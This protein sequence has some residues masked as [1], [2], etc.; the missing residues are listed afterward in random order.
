MKLSNVIGILFQMIE[1]TRLALIPTLKDIYK[2]PYL[3]FHPFYVFFTNVWAILGPAMDEHEKEM[4]R[5]L[6]DPHARGVVLDL[7]AGHGHIIKYLDQSKVTK[8]IAL[9][10]NICMHSKIR[11]EAS[12]HGFTESNGNFL[13]IS[14]SASDISSVL[15][16]LSTSIENEEKSRLHSASGIIIEDIRVDTIMTIRSAC[17]FPSPEKTLSRLAKN[18]LKPGGEFLFVEHVLSERKDVAWWQRFWSPI[19]EA[20]AGCRLDRPTHLWIGGIKDLDGEGRTIDM[21]S[22]SEGE[23]KRLAEDPEE[24]LFGHRIGR[25]VKHL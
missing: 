2:N 13:L 8:Y 17:S 4:K 9:E 12:S 14:C 15:F 22:A 7:G 5:G 19:W 1:L 10:P 11:S 20:F 3:I 24:N 23:A 25:F 6:I 16:H 18:V 21:W